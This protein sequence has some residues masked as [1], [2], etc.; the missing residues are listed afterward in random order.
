MLFWPMEMVP[1]RTTE[2]MLFLTEVTS[3]GSDAL[4]TEADDR[5][6]AIS[7]EAPLNKIQSLEI[8]Y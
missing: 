3:D 5:S 1:F 6:D 8:A 2:V 7:T 4:W